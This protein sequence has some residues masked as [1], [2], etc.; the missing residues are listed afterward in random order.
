MGTIIKPLS[1][2]TSAEI[3]ATIETRSIPGKEGSIMSWF[4]CIGKKTIS[5]EI[6]SGT[7]TKSDIERA[8]ISTFEA[9]LLQEYKARGYDVPTII[10]E[11]D[12]FTMD[13][14]KGPSL[15]EEFFFDS[16]INTD[17]VISRLSEAH[18]IVRKMDYDLGDIMTDEE[19]AFFRYQEANKLK[20]LGLTEEERKLSPYS[21]KIERRSKNLKIPFSKEVIDSLKLA[22]TLLQ[23]YLIK[24]GAFFVE[25]NGKN[26]IGNTRIDMNGVFEGFGDSFLLDTPYMLSETYWISR[27][28]NSNFFN[29][30]YRKIENAKNYLI[31]EKSK[32]QGKNEEDAVMA[33]QLS[34]IFRNTLEM[35][36]AYKQASEI[37]EE[38]ELGNP[39]SQLRQYQHINQ[40]AAHYEMADTAMRSVLEMWPDAG[41][42]R[43]CQ[44]MQRTFHRLQS[45]IELYTKGMDMAFRN[46]ATKLKADDPSTLGSYFSIYKNFR[47]LK[48]FTRFRSS[49]P[50]NF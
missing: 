50:T 11:G 40:I 42:N 29:P 30:R 45:N 39:L 38:A 18:R 49:F 6:D 2:G 7:V 37:A 4:D 48:E 34:R 13:Y 1:G 47:D 19:R 15:L 32:E 10:I 36:Y 27:I 41:L 25:A 16:K 9:R 26:I 46:I 23:P 28:S 22:E 17:Q 43:E 5:F 8:G 31:A 35:L 33:F 24:D 3:E 12:S 21:S 44:D 20:Q 14:V